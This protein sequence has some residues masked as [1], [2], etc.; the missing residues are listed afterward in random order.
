MLLIHFIAQN[1]IDQTELLVP[2]VLLF[3]LTSEVLLNTGS[4]SSSTRI[5]GFVDF[6]FM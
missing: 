6:S 3:F 2:L 5:L 4:D 1:R